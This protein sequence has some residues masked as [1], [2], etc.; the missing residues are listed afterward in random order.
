MSRTTA[1]SLLSR[2]ANSMF[3]ANRSYEKAI[4]LAAEIGGSAIR[5]DDW[6]ES[7][8]KV[9]III[10]STG[11]PH[12]V[13]LPEHIEQ[14]RRM[15]KYRTILMVDIAVPRDIDPVVGDIDEIYLYDV[16]GLQ[17]LA[18]EA[19]ERRLAQILSLIHI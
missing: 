11:A 16:D 13:I 6:E 18:S 17:G 3:V 9:D 4:E 8:K 14:V 10:S 5:F 12:H 19:R 2:G 15:R 1:Q 7:L